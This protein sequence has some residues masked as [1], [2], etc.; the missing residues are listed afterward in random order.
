MTVKT[1]TVWS[2]TNPPGP[3]PIEHQRKLAQMIADGKTDGEWERV[4]ESDQVISIRTWRD[5]AAA[6]EWEEFGATQDKRSGFISGSIE[7]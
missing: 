3:L 2:I 1:K 6:R 4:V 5:E 7:S